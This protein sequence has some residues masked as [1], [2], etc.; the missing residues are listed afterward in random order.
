MP[1]ERADVV[2]GRPQHDVLH[3]AGLDDVATFHDDDAVAQLDGL[4]KVVADEEDGLFQAGLE[5]QQFVL[6]LAAD[7]RIKRR[8]WLVHQQDVGI[9][10]KGA[11]EADPLLHAAR[12]LV[13]VF[14]RPGRQAH[15]VELFVDD[16]TR[17]GPLGSAH[18]EGEPD[19][20]AHGSPGQEGELLKHHGDPARP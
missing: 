11:G 4:V 16:A 2:G 14:L 10:R 8:E 12:K 15:H 20:V 13:G 5:F 6:Q 7:Q 18:L 1:H 17:V 3:G 19:V 9:C